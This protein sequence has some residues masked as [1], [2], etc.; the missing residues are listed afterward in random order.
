MLAKI[1]DIIEIETGQGLAY[2]Q[3]THRIPPY[4]AL[5]RVFAG[6]HARRPDVVELAKAPVVFSTF[7]PLNSALRQRVVRVVGRTDVARTN[8]V[9]PVFRD[10]N[11]HPVTRKVEEWWLWDGVREWKV[12]DLSPEQRRLPILGVWDIDML[13]AR[14]E[15]GWRPELDS[16]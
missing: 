3:Y 14:I 9:S 8:Q 4:G 16:R 10:G 6:T 13:V 5:I 12:G 7:F 15:D 11:P 1:G 2:A